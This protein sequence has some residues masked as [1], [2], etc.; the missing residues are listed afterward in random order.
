MFKNVSVLFTDNQPDLPTID[1]QIAKIRNENQDFETREQVL[2]QATK[3]RNYPPNSVRQ[4][5]KGTKILFPEKREGEGPT[6]RVSGSMTFPD[7]RL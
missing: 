3:D 6:R 2:R 5:I 1:F 7:L 4:Y